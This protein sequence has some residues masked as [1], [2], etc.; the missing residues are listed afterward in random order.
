[1]NHNDDKY[2]RKDLV[3]ILDKECQTRKDYHMTGM[4]GKSDDSL[5]YQLMT[6][7]HLAGQR[8]PSILITQAGCDRSDDLQT[9][10]EI[11]QERVLTLLSSFCFMINYRQ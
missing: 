7:S 6:F 10:G 9:P 8:I 2:E 1:M 3:T 5:R 4:N 11:C